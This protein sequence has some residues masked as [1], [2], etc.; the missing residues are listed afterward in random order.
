MPSDRYDVWMASLGPSEALLEE[1][2]EGKCTWAAFK[3]RYVEELFAPSTIDGGN[4]SIKNHGQKFTL[5]LLKRLAE[6][7]DVTLMCHCPDPRDHCHAGVLADLIA[8][9]RV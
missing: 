9:A 7:Q 8:S 1:I 2:H 5:R 4:D 3:R 6:T